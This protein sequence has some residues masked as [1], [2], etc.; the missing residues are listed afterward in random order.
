[1]AFAKALL[2]ILLL[3]AVVA[4]IYTQFRIKRG[5]KRDAGE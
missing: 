2:V 3:A 4:G 5:R 1:M